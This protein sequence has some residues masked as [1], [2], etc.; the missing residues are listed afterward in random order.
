MAVGMRFNC[1]ELLPGGYDT[2]QAR[3]VLKA[4]CDRGLIDFADLDVAV[5]PMQLKYGMP[6]VFIEEHFYRPYVEKVRSAAGAVPVLSVLGRVTRMADAEAAIASGLCDMVG[7]A[8][9]LIAEPQ[10][11]KL[12]REGKEEQGR[13]CIACN[14]C[15]AG[16]GDG[17]FGCS[18]NPGSYRE[19]TWGIDSFSPAASRSNVAVIGGGPG[20]ME[21]A[22]VAALKGHEVTLFEARDSSGRRLGAVGKAARPRVLPTRGRLVGAGTRSTWRNSTTW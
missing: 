9:E 1:D 10:F 11:V 14:W 22:R 20:G 21:A 6:S 7:S 2:G 18:I 19:R 5:E 16:S 3:E 12:A 4:V 8:R 17:V 13:T 15:L